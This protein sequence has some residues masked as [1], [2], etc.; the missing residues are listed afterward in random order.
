MSML[1][2]ESTSQGNGWTFRLSPETRVALE[3]RFGRAGVG[4][5]LFLGTD[6]RPSYRELHPP[7]WDHIAVLLT[8][9]GLDELEEVGGYRVV[10]VRSGKVVSSRGNSQAH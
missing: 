6:A 2:I 10:D 3:R 8:G 4:S 9:I 7:L 5:S 1:I